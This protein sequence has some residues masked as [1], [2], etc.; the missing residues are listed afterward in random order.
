M[1]AAGFHLV[2]TQYTVLQSNEALPL[3]AIIACKYVMTCDYWIVIDRQQGT[4]TQPELD[5]T[6]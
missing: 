5:L 4:Y 1:Q 3:N 2:P 6:L